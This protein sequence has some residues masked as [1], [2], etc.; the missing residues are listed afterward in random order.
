[1]SKHTK[2]PFSRAYVAI[3]NAIVIP[4][5]GEPQAINCLPLA[6]SAPVLYEALKQIA[7]YWKDGRSLSPHALLE[8][9][10]VTIEQRV[11]AALVQAEG[12]EVQHGS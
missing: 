10:D 5:S 11:K 4:C 6:K 3:G 7:E 1:M 8:D 9:G 12:R 2:G